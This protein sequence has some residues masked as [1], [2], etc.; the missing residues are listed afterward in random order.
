MN[1]KLIK[2]LIYLNSKIKISNFIKFSKKIFMYF[3]CFYLNKK[4]FSDA[5]NTIIIKRIS[6]NQNLFKKIVILKK[7][8]NYL[9]NMKPL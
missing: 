8:V 5:K 6:L 3:C 4:L 9:N 2:M 7:N 1:F